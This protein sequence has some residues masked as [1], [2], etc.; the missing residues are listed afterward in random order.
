MLWLCNDII[1]LILKEL[2]DDTKSLYSCLLVNRTWCR[3][4]VPIL[5]QNPSNKK[6]YISYKVCNILFNV[7]LSH[8]SEESRN[9]LKNQGIDLFKEKYQQP[10]FNY[11]SF[12]RHLNLHNLE[13]IMENVFTKNFEMSKK[14]TIGNEIMKLF[15]NSET[16]FVSLTIPKVNLCHISGSELCF[17]KLEYL[18]CDYTNSNILERLA[19]MSTSIKNLIF[20]YEYNNTIN[21]HGINRL[22]EVQ[23]NLKRIN[24][25]SKLPRDELFC[26]TLEESMIKCA[27]TLQYLKISWIPVPKFFSYLINLVSL[28]II[29]FTDRTNLNY[30]GK[31]IFPLLNSLKS[32]KVVDVPSNICKNIID[33]TKGNL[34]EISIIYEYQQY[35]PDD[36]GELIQKIYQKCPNLKFLELTMY[37]ENIS[38]FKNLLINCQSL[39]SLEIID[40]NIKWNKLFEVLKFSPIS[41][42]RFKFSTE[43]KVL[44]LNLKHLKLFLDNWKDRNPMLLHLNIGYFFI[45]GSRQLQQYIKLRRRLNVFLQEYKAK[46]FDV[47]VSPKWTKDFKWT[48]NIKY[49][50]L[51]GLKNSILAINQ[52]P[53]LENDGAVLN[54]LN[55]NGKY[56]PRTDQDLREMLQQ[57]FVSKSSFKFTVHIETPLNPFNEWTFPKLC[58]LYGLSD[59]PNPNI[60][61]YPVFHFGCVDTKNEKYKKRCVNFL[62]NWR[63]ELQQL[64]STYPMRPPKVS[65]RR[66]RKAN[67]IDDGHGC[68]SER[69]DGEDLGHITWLLEELQKVDSAVNL[70]KEREIQ[71]HRSLGSL[72]E[73]QILLLSLSIAWSKRILKLLQLPG[74]KERLEEDR[75]KYCNLTALKEWEEAG[76][77][78]SEDEEVL[79]MKNEKNE[80]HH[81]ANSRA[82]D[83]N[84]KSK[85][86]PQNM[87]SIRRG[88]N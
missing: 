31:G 12:W 43:F 34:I 81:F 64:L 76:E 60:N 20:N 46:E 45:T 80:A 58:E 17:S 10:L 86:E 44:F 37:K 29:N 30:L 53:A 32:L 70:D 25:N 49:V 14:S 2:Q 4:T 21:N 36:N 41:L 24:F 35:N 74:I 55:D 69:Q 65:T 61:V 22:I 40:H 75:K 19:I 54:I 66:K 33:S 77:P 67:E 84:T 88:Q 51:V 57:L 85:S 72:A 39:I 9:N 87:R 56:S 1:V 8:L 6:D 18:D 23:K 15:I 50:T 5:W 27:D 38:E 68:G 71:K 62:M 11:I 52:T 78:F 13:Y 59:D 63:L 28:E 82:V 73:S 16:K 26:K 42:F 7:V 3:L 48:V 83:N 79:C 47:I